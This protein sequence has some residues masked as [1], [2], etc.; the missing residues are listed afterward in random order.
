MI[1]CSPCEAKVALSFV[2]KE[3]SQ[4]SLPV[5]CACHLQFSTAINCHVP[6]VCGGIEFTINTVYNLCSISFLTSPQISS[7][8]DQPVL[9]W[10][11][12]DDFM[13]HTAILASEHKQLNIN[14]TNSLQHLLQNQ[15]PQQNAFMQSTLLQQRM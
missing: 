11:V 12:L 15:F 10:L 6:T 7:S 3:F 14:H 9:E 1:L 2:M 5:Q 4:N 8:L 13:S